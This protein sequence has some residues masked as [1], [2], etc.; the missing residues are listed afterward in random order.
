MPEGGS[1]V[2]Q[3][4]GVSGLDGVEPVVSAALLV[5]NFMELPEAEGVYIS[6]PDLRFGANHNS[7]TGRT[8]RELLDNYVAAYGEPPS[9]GYWG[10]AYDAATMLLHA[11]DPV[12]VELDGVLYID[13]QALRDAVKIRTSRASAVRSGVT[14]TVTAVR[15]ASPC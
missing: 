10:H 3:V 14:T 4:G 8:A 2:Q 12:A 11:I 9:A 13:R 1:V 5:D 6:G 15:S 7:L